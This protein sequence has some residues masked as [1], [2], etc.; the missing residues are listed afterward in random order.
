MG[1]TN[2]P[3][4]RRIFGEGYKL[5]PGFIEPFGCANVKNKKASL[6]WIL[7]SG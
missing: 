6:S 7:R 5:R 1:R 3:V 4:Y 2:V